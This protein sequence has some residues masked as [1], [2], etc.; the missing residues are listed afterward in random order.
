MVISGKKNKPR[1]DRPMPI[2][3]LVNNMS[4]ASDALHQ[5]DGTMFGRKAQKESAPNHVI[6]VNGIEKEYVVGKATKMDFRGSGED[7]I[8]T[9]EKVNKLKESYRWTKGK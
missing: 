7:Q 9:T 8:A 1:K 4:M 5:S 6:M 3:V 2:W